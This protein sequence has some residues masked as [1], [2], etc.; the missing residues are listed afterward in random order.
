[1]AKWLKKSKQGRKG[2][3]HWGEHAL[4]SGHWR[5][6]STDGRGH[7]HWIVEIGPAYV[8]RTEGAARVSSYEKE[9]EAEH[10][11]HPLLSWTRRKIKYKKKEKSCERKKPEMHSRSGLCPQRKQRNNQITSIRIFMFLHLD[12]RRQRNNFKS[13][14]LWNFFFFFI[15]RLCWRYVFNN[16]VFKKRATA[17][18][19]YSLM[20]FFFFFNIFKQIVND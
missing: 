13:K 5:K 15:L 17:R 4:I 11:V 3:I 8:E 12:K 1:M 19:V 20:R 10:T 2:N 14:W 6:P 9:E 7:V 18:W 16:M